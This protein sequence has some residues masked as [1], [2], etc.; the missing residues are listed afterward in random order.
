[1]VD[2]FLHR[3][4]DRRFLVL[5]EVEALDPLPKAAA[6]NG[7]G[8]AMVV[9]GDIG[10]GTVPILFASAIRMSACFGLGLSSESDL[11]ARAASTLRAISSSDS[12]VIVI[13]S[14]PQ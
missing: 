6:A 11:S 14:M 1:V 8:L 9:D 5:R 13:S 4:G 3:L 7:P 12:L 10:I 2:G